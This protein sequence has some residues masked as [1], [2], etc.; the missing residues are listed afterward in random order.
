MESRGQALIEYLFILALIAVVGGHFAGAFGEYVGHGMGTLNSV[1]SDHLSVGICQDECFPPQLYQW[2]GIIGFYLSPYLYCL[3]LLEL[4]VVSWGDLKS[5]RI[6]NI[7]PLL[8]VMGLVLLA[9]GGGVEFFRF[10]YPLAFLGV[11]FLFFQLNIMG[12]G[13][14]KF[15]A[16]FFLLIPVSRHEQFFIILLYGIILFAGGLFS[17]H[18]MRNWRQL[19]IILFTKEWRQ[20]RDIYGKKFPF[21]PII[22]FSWLIFGHIIRIWK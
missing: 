3:L 5:R 8:N 9:I 18:S 20:L 10:I 21:A 17:Y 14:S 7:W 15:L 12:G 19:Q 2:Q 13:D 4:L 22:L 11:G 16:T 1:L 6:P